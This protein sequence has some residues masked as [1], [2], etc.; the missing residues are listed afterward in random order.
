MSQRKMDA[1]MIYAEDTNEKL[2]IMFDFMVGFA[3]MMLPMWSGSSVFKTQMDN[4]MKTS[5][6]ITSLSLLKV[7]FVVPFYGYYDKPYNTFKHD[8]KDVNIRTTLRLYFCCCNFSDIRDRVSGLSER[9]GHDM[10]MMQP[11]AIGLISSEINTEKMILE[12]MHIF[13][14]KAKVKF[15]RKYK[16]FDIH[17]N[18]TS[19]SSIDSICNQVVSNTLTESFQGYQIRMDEHSSD[20]NQDIIKHLTKAD[21]VF[22]GDVRP[23]C[24][25]YLD[26]FY[27][28][29]YDKGTFI[30]YKSCISSRTTNAR[31]DVGNRKLTDA[32]YAL[33]KIKE[34]LDE[35]RGIKE[36]DN[37]V[38]T[39]VISKRNIKS[40]KKVADVEHIDITHVKFPDDSE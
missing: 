3:R 11:I 9:H 23:F 6:I 21:D 34:I 35:D 7:M 36:I 17:I 15:D 30:E 38:H 12:K 2:T 37:M 4:L 13:P 18:E 5:S 20:I 8:D 26:C 28:K 22:Y 39:G 40:L 29:V 33:Y 25:K 1:L 10:Y 14:A 19:T 16:A 27:T 31:P 32:H 24:Q